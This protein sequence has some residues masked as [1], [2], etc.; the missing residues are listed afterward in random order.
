VKDPVLADWFYFIIFPFF[1]VYLIIFNPV[2]HELLHDF[3][4]KVHSTGRLIH[5]VEG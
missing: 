3:S 1:S 5:T 2:L 4:V